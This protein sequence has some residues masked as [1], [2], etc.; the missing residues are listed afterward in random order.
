MCEIP[1][2]TGKEAVSAFTKAGFYLDRVSGSHHILKR[3]GHRFNLSVPVHSG[4]TIGKSL[5][6]KLIE[7]AGLT[8]EEFKD[9]L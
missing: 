1:R 8:T 9:L 7:I 3:A 2:I 6:A 4:R 5:L